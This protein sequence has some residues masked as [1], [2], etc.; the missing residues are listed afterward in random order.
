MYFANSIFIRL[1]NFLPKAILLCLAMITFPF[2]SMA[3]P[4]LNS[5]PKVGLAL[6]GGGAKGL[7]HIGVLKVLKEAGVKI[8]YISGNSMGSIIGGLYAVGYD[9][10]FLDH[11]AHTTNWTKVLSD[12]ISRRGYSLEEK[13]EQ[14]KYAAVFPI[15]NGHLKLP[16]GLLSGQNLSLLLCRLTWPA[17]IV[18]DFSKLPTPFVCVATDLS[19][20]QVVDLKRGFLP[21]ALRA[22]MA[23][24]TIFTP[25][26]I[27]GKLLVDGLLSRNFPVKEVKDLGANYVIGVDVGAPLYRTKDLNNMFNIVDQ[28]FSFRNAQD[29]K[30][31][32]KL[33]NILIKPNLKNFAP[34]DFGNVDSIIAIGEQAARRHWDKLV[35]LAELQKRCRK[36]EPHF[37][38]LLNIDSIHIE[39]I[40]IEG[41]KN[42]SRKLVLSRLG[43]DAPSWVTPAQVEQAITRVYGSK[44]FER[45][46]YRLYSDSNGTTLIVRVLE[47]SK[48]YFKL[49]F[50]YNTN[51]HSALLLNVTLRNLVFEG[52]RWN[53]TAKLSEF[54]KFGTSHFFHINRNPGLGS[55][56]SAFIEKFRFTR[57]TSNK[58]KEEYD[59]RRIPITLR[60][61]TLFSNDYAFGLALWRQYSYITS[62]IYDPDLQDYKDSFLADRATLFIRA[63]T[64]D[65]LYFTHSGIQFY[66][67]ASHIFHIQRIHSH[68][69]YGKFQRYSISFRQYLPLPKMEH[70]T[71]IRGFFVGSIQGKRP[72]LPDY[73][74]LLSNTDNPREQVVGF[75]GYHFL[76]RQALQ[77]ITAE[78]GFQ[79]EPWTERFAVLKFHAAR[80]REYWDKSLWARSF[81]FGF[82]FTMGA[83]IPIGPL[84]LT[85]SYNSDKKQLLGYFNFGY[86][87]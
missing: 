6:S 54:P 21:D 53:L 65:R 66:A 16:G 30:Q 57:F 28:T 26:K 36:T 12:H 82:E 25:V 3:Q 10:A 17:H 20:G 7:A 67:C 83:R 75:P 62:L 46:T 23:I 43:I 11:L 81:V 60:F 22:S 19:N 15:I 44:F 77:L 84:F 51:D 27:N 61:A 31:Q 34:F 70:L 55:G 79:Y 86:N 5:C 37:I 73:L 4:A 13:D 24:P 39:K 14:E 71:F 49:G 50:H 45:V 59:Y 41:L 56:F 74:F 9:A 63:D 52:S 64:Y 1:K 68:Q 18:N 33:C 47:R 32:S 8:D 35:K 80:I 48:N 2:F 78:I 29:V 69:S 72:I 85:L 76:E 42:T 40:K 38:P 58:I 87:F